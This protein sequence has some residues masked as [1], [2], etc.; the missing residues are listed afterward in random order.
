MNKQVT[1]DILDKKL[2][3]NDQCIVDKIIDKVYELEHRDRMK[4]VLQQLKRV[5][6]SRSMLKEMKYRYYCCCC[7]SPFYNEQYY[8]SEN[9][10]FDIIINNKC[11]FVKRGMNYKCEVEGCGRAYC[12]PCSY[13]GC[14]IATQGHPHNHGHCCWN[15]MPHN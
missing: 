7:G 10:D 12:W 6:K 9:I 1:F 15:D 11:K 13:V 4:T 5:Y 14:P 2:H 3:N 8:A